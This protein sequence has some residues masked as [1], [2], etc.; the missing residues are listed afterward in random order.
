MADRVL[1]YIS[2][3]SNMDKPEQQLAQ[4]ITSISG[5]QQSQL[6]AISPFYETAAL[7]NTDQA[8]FVNAVVSLHTELTALRLLQAL[9]AIETQQ[10]RI[11][12]ERWGPRSLDL[13]VLIYGQEQW[14]SSQ[15]WLPHPRMSER[16]FVLQPLHDIA[17]NLP[18]GQHTLSDYIAAC[19]DQ[20][21]A[22]LETSYSREMLH[23]G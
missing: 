9:Q 20:Y 15:L 13:D 6:K 21:I 14:R 1:A 12:Q 2:L 3:G 18:I 8:N 5:L 7:G 11:R 10:G 16:K 4:A 17:P 23:A 22:P 19:A